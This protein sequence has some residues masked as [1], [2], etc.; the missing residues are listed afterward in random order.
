MGNIG[1]VKR[2]VFFFFFSWKIDMFLQ[3]L[4]PIVHRQREQVDI[5]CRQQ[6]HK[7]VVGQQFFPRWVKGLP[8]K[9]AVMNHMAFPSVNTL[10][11]LCAK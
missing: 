3:R 9:L 10:K 5:G 7:Y 4:Y 2:T 6:Y 8:N 11:R 1:S